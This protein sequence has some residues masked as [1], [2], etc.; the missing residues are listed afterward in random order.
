M[1]I[2]DSGVRCVDW[3]VARNMLVSGSWDK[4]IKLWDP[5]NPQPL[6]KS[7][8]LPGRVLALSSAGE[9]LVVAMSGKLVHIFDV[10]KWVR[11]PVS[12]KVFVH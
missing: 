2:H 4:C 3:I 9:R 12:I 8:P 10:R 11:P 5:R 1:G 7:V 6:V